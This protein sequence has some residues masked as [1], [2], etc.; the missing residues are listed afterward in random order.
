MSRFWDFM[1][2]LGGWVAFAVMFVALADC[3]ARETEAR[4][5]KARPVI[6]SECE[7]RD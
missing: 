4:A 7:E 3:T 6:I 5:E 2:T 1:S